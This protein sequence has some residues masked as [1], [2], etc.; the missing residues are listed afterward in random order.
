MLCENFKI[1]KIASSRTVPT[2]SHSGECGD[3]S[4]KMLHS[5]RSSIYNEFGPNLERN[6]NRFDRSNEGCHGN[7]KFKAVASVVIHIISR[8]EQFFCFYV[9]DSIY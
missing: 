2:F 8:D 6:D 9:D 1:G 5:P 7:A 4:A 3:K